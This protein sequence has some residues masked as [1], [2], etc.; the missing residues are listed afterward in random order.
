MPFMFG[1]DPTFLLLIP[2]MIFA[3]WAQWKVMHTYNKFAKVRAA[4]GLADYA[5][6]GDLRASVSHRLGFRELGLSIGLH[7]VERIHE[8]LRTDPGRFADC[9]SEAYARVEP[10]EPYFH[11]ATAIETFWLHPA[12]WD[13][14]SWLAHRDI[15]EVMLATSL[16]PDG[17][18]TFWSVG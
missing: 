14:R 13:A 5:R 1:W 11:L 17:Y 9:R 16:L 18:L 7:A 15:N 12:H 4:N 10:L 3:F 8:A 2:A 6:R